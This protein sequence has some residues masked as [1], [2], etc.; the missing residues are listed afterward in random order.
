MKPA[1]VI[2]LA[3][4]AC[5]P[6]AGQSDI[7]MIAAPPREANCKLDMVQVD[8]T[9]VSFN[10]KWDVLGYVNLADNGAQ[11]PFAESNKK[12][13]R[14]RACAMGGTVVAI[15]ANAMASNRFNQQGSII[16]YMVLRPKTWAQGPQAF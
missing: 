8:I 7:R 9:A 13:V 15:A 12:L 14:P 16:S 6:K 1:L 11:D 4:A 10:Q 5:A 2:V 3:L